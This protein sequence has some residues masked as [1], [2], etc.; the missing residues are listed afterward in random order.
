MDILRVYQTE[1]ACYKR[2]R[3]CTPVGILVHSTG[4]VN[5]ELR[6]YVDAPNELGKNQYNNHWNKDTADKCVHAFIGYDKDKKVIVAETLPYEIACWGCGSG[7]NGSY[8]RD[9]VAHIQFE[10]CEGGKDDA[11]YY[12]RAITVAADYC[13]YLCEKFGWG[14]DKITSH[15]EAHD[16]G[17]ASNHGDPQS[18]MKHFDDDMEQFRARV[19][20]RL[21]SAETP[22]KSPVIPEGEIPSEETKTQENANIGGKTVMIELNT[23]RN[24][25]K[26][27]QVKTL[28]R[29][30]NALGYDCGTVDGIWGSKTLAAVKAFQKAKGL[31][32]D[33]ICGKNTWTALLK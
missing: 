11:D 9:P 5:R 24:G 7:A 25:N 22:A 33:G 30:L 29:L 16:A 21:G 19:A 17:Y 26:G 4:A 13:A 2:N 8:N 32:V 28:Q 1:N 31:T 18:Y 20:R 27:N 12:A 6:R 14:A 23:L 3:K 15:K 10:I